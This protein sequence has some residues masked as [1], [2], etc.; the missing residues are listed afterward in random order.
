VAIKLFDM[1]RYLAG[2]KGPGDFGVSLSLSICGRDESG[3][4]L[5]QLEI[6]DLKAES[7][8]IVL[9][10]WHFNQLIAEAQFNLQKI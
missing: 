8:V 5:I 4:V 6:D 2:Y 1:N 10:K 3:E 9:T 7:A